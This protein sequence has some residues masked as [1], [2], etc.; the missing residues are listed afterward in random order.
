MNNKRYPESILYNVKLSIRDGG[1]TA[2]NLP[3]TLTIYTPAYFKC[4]SL[5]INCVTP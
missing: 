1:G 4:F 3:F 2:G 5:Q